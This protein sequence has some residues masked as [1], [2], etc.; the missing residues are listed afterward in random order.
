MPSTAQSAVGMLSGSSS[1]AIPRSSFD[2]LT[3][4]D[5][6]PPVR[7]N[8]LQFTS[9]TAQ[10]PSGEPSE[11]PSTALPLPLLES[12]TISDPPLPVWMG[13]AT[14]PCPTITDSGYASA[15]KSAQPGRV[16]ETQPP[17]SHNAEPDEDDA[18]TTY[19]AATAV[20]HADVQQ[21]VS[22]VCNEIAK[23]LGQTPALRQLAD[24]PDTLTQLIKA[25]CINIGRESPRQMNR[26]VMYFAHKHYR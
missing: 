20:A 16:G 23:R 26:D 3:I 8:K 25:F 19:S 6:P 24:R 4:S 17:Y 15:S 22:E 11:S 12:W 5:P 14:A 2:T 1:T 9:A 10:S 13:V 21:Y 18:K 7:E